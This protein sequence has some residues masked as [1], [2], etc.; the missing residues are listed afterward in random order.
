MAITVATAKEKKQESYDDFGRANTVRAAAHS[1]T[2]MAS[3][4]R[5]STL[6]HCHL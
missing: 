5:G 1:A 6:G 3:R 2:A 4:R